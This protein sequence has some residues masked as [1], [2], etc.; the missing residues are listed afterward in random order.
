SAVL[1]GGLLAFRA[2]RTFGLAFLT[3][4]AT[5][6]FV[7]LLKWTI[8]RPSAVNTFSFPS[9]HVAF[10][11]A[12]GGLVAVIGTRG[13]SRN[14][15]TSV[16]AVALS[17]SVLIGFSRIYLSA[18][19]PSDVIGG[20][21]F[22]WTMAGIFGL[23]G[24]KIQEPSIRPVV[25]GLATTA[26]LLAAWGVHATKSFDADMGRYSPRQG[27]VRMTVKNW[28]GGGWKDIPAARIDLKGE[29]EE[30]LFFQVAAPL[31]K[32]KNAFQASGWSPS[33][34]MGWSKMTQFLGAKKK[35]P[36]L[37]P[38]PLLHN[39]RLP[40]LTLTKR[41]GQ[42]GRRNVIRLWETG[43]EI[44]D[45]P[46]RPMVL[47]GSMTVERAVH[48]LYGI[49]VLRDRPASSQRV[50]MLVASIKATASLCVFKRPGA[51]LVS[52]RATYPCAKEEQ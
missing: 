34:A 45:I 52:A 5:S 35:L 40:L 1:L 17:V 19:W 42:P 22:G 16:W 9:G 36:A 29:F 28:L 50:G 48:P 38:L 49:N 23:F 46:R 7:P 14:V 11:A 18:H 51:W 3:L 47:V 30:P 24:E 26:A 2:W 12:L 4:A 27:V 21:L 10:A 20:L 43:I 25:L 6:V 32:I 8:N 15:R 37:L 39:G 33:A 31:G 13:L 44:D 41:T